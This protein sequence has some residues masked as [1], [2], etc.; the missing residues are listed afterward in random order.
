[1]DTNSTVRKFYAFFIILIVLC[2]I[3]DFIEQRKST[4]APVEKVRIMTHFEESSP[5]FNIQE[6]I[7]ATC[8]LSDK[9]V[10]FLKTHKTASSTI[11]NILMRYAWTYN[12]TVHRPANGFL[13][14]DFY[15]PIDAK[16]IR[17][18][19]GA[20]CPYENHL[21]V[22]ELVRKYRQVFKTRL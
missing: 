8:Q 9:K 4:G 15:R 3:G 13:N 20:E 10:Y 1:M 7:L 12:K 16:Q 19:P 11:E 2:I 18:V 21:P 5:I 22:W 6:P 14:F 17:P